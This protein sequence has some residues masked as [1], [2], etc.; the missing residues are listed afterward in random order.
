MYLLHAGE[1]L[2]E[3]VNELASSQKYDNLLIES[4]GIS[5]P[6]PVAT[7]FDFRDE[8]G[9]SLSDVAQLDTMVT[10]VDAANLINQYSSTDFLKDTGESLG[11]D[12][13]RTI[14]DLLVD[15]IE[16]ANV[17]VINKVDRITHEQLD[18][19]RG[20]VRSL[21][22]KAKVYETIESNVALKHVMNTGLFNLEDAQT[23][24]LWAQELYNFKDHT[25]ETEEYGITSFVYR[26][27]KPFDPTKIY[28]FFNSENLVW[29][30]LKV[31]G[32]ASRPDYA[33]EM[34]QAGAIIRH[35]G[36]GR[37]WVSVPK[38]DWP[39]DTET[40]EDIKNN[41]DEVFGDRRQELVFI[42]F[43]DEMNPKK[44]SQQLD[45]CLADEIWQKQPQKGQND[46]FPVW[47][48]EPED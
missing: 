44:I 16:F 6:L 8:D 46:P 19:V 39:E 2:L 5:E 40:L 25:P 11:D 3:Q 1:D 4:T 32:S 42:G 9:H 26:T 45:A 37:W 27:P 28:A 33:G 34:S 13:E 36:M 29:S 31:F 12:D 17:I 23:H 41:W 10:V 38:A 48:E 20:L 14:V 21:N 47:F 30:G 43:K 7:T 35:Q 18:I 24:P 15:Q 22:A